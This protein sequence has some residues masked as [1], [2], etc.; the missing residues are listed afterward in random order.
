MAQK[1]SLTITPNLARTL[2]NKTADA[3]HIAALAFLS[4]TETTLQ[5]DFL[6]EQPWPAAT[7]W[8]DLIAPYKA[9]LQTA[10]AEVSFMFYNYA[11]DD[12]PLTEITAPFNILTNLVREEPK[13]FEAFARDYGYRE[14]DSDTSAMQVFGDIYKEIMEGYTKVKRLW[15]SDQIKHLNETV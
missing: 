11:Q 2:A 8:V 4:D 13:P 5:V 15:T 7:D 12:A 6:A 14:E 9:T 1:P 3:R 10:R